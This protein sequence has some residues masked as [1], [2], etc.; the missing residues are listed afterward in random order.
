[1]ALFPEAGGASLPLQTPS[2]PLLALVGVHAGPWSSPAAR[3][4][5]RSTYGAWLPPDMLLVFILAR[6]GL[7]ADATAFLATEHAVH[8][9]LLLVDGCDEG[10]N[11]KT[12]PHL[13]AAV[14]VFG[15]AFHFLVKLDTDSFLLPIQYGDMLRSLL[16]ALAAQPLVYGGNEFAQGRYRWS[17]D[18]AYMQGGGY[19]LSSGLA[20]VV[21]KDCAGCTNLAF[22]GLRRAQYSEDQSL[23]LFLATH[24][25]GSSILRVRLN[26]YQTSI[27][28]DDESVSGRRLLTCFTRRLRRPVHRCDPPPLLLLH[29][30]KT[31]DEWLAVAAF[32]DPRG[33]G[34]TEAATSTEFRGFVPPTAELDSLVE[35]EPDWFLGS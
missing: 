33:A 27:V 31:E 9:D 16:P 11:T 20:A 23:G 1:V 19:F 18:A 22:A 6:R 5:I 35:L 8:G 14:A 12:Y 3:N 15:A 29:A 28:A 2:A 24:P 30:I 21:A 10:V 17:Q 4:R 25:L 26:R 32:Y 7:T 34:A 13:A